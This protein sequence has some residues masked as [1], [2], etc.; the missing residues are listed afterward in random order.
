MYDSRR[1]C[2]TIRDLNIVPTRESCVRSTFIASAVQTTFRACF[3]PSSQCER[4]STWPNIDLNGF[5]C[6]NPPA[7]R[8][9]TLRTTRALA[10][11]CNNTHCR[12]VHTLR[13]PSRYAVGC[14]AV[15]KMARIAKR[16]SRLKLHC[17]VCAAGTSS[18]SLM[19]C[20]PHEG[21]PVKVLRTISTLL[22]ER[23]EF[24]FM[25]TK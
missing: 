22:V 2:A 24:P 7:F 11:D 15:A 10:D 18:V 6:C 16:I 19:V 20:S 4:S 14:T 9:I 13:A 23:D 17:C 1:R 3:V 25:V 5:A 8:L 12:N 21:A